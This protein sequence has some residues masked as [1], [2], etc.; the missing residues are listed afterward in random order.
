MAINAKCT[1]TAVHN[2]SLGEMQT[3]ATRGRVALR[4]RTKPIATGDYL[5]NS[6]QGG[7]TPSLISTAKTKT[8]VVSLDTAY[9]PLNELFSDLS[10][11]TTV[12]LQDIPTQ[13]PA[14]ARLAVKAK[15]PTA[16][17]SVVWKDTGLTLSSSEPLPTNASGR[18]SSLDIND[19]QQ[20]I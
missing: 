10:F 20:Q 16:D 17:A 9:A 4:T 18:R 13:A 19:Q 15:S 2:V 5:V 3:A 6:E 1:Q 8:G 7:F 11:T 14:T 12:K